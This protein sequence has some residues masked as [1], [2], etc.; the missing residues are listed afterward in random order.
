MSFIGDLRNG[1][2]IILLLSH[3]WAIRVR[4]PLSLA[5]H[6]DKKNTVLVKCSHHVSA[7]WA[8]WSCKSQCIL[9]VCVNASY[10]LSH[11]LS[12][13]LCHFWSLLGE[14]MG[15]CFTI[16]YLMP[17]SVQLTSES[18]VSV[19]SKCLFSF[20]THGQQHAGCIGKEAILCSWYM[21]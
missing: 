15:H 14:E 2:I 3:S 13:S 4:K 10:M 16:E 1:T 12:L 7:F 21:Y 6:K 5:I 19:L 11:S 20:C 18:T 17:T 8:A 9:S